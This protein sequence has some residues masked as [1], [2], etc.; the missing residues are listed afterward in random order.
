MP[1][2]FPLNSAGVVEMTPGSPGA[3]GHACIYPAFSKDR[4]HYVH[5]SINRNRKM[6]QKSFSEKRCGGAENAMKLAQAWRDAIVSKHPPMSLMSFCSILRSNNTSGVVG[7]HRTTKR[8]RGKSGR[9]SEHSYWQ[10]RI[11]KAD[12]TNCVRY[13][14]V[15][16]FGEDGA[17][18]LAID[19]RKQGISALKDVPFREKY[20]PQPVSNPADIALLEETIRSS[21]ERRARKI[22]ER[23]AKGAQSARSAAEKLALASAAQ[24][25]A[26][27]RAAKSGAERYIGRYAAPNGTSYYWRVGFHRQGNHH[28]KCFSDSVYGGEAEALLAAKAWRDSLLCTLSSDSKAAVVV[29]VKANNTSGVAGG[30]AG[31]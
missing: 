6:F 8:H 22:A 17:K 1:T 3:A 28:R 21:A 13:F 12:G 10:A 18:K 7:I 23:A 27:D 9:V 20:Q 5:V 15:K 4:G 25:E 24:E 19:A 30:R 11:P 2:A 26:L 31:G 16:T 29:R 14:S